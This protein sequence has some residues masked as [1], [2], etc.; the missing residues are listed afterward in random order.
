[1]ICLVRAHLANDDNCEMRCVMGTKAICALLTC[2]AIVAARPSAACELD[3]T[4]AGGS[5]KATL[6]AQV[7]GDSASF[8]KAT[9]SSETGGGL[10]AYTLAPRSTTRIAL[11]ALPAGRYAVAAFEDT[12][13]SGKLRKSLAGI[14]EDPYGFSQDATGIL[15]PPS[16][17]QA[18]VDCGNDPVSITIHLR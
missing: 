1:M 13:G 3:I 11:L 4:I 18:A 8:D 12:S 6:F 17:D 5:G 15:G 10:V 2:A 14:P 16:F 9:N 7:F